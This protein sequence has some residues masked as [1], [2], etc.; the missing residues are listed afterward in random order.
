MLCPSIS[1]WNTQRS[2]IGKLMASTWCITVVCS[3]S[4]PTLDSSTAAMPSAVARCSCQNC[5]GETVPSQSTTWPMRANSSA[6]Y[7]A[8]S[9]DVP[10]SSAIQPRMPRVQSH[11]KAMKALGG[12]WGSAGG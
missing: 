12:R 3:A 8:S 9:A 2:R 10:V 6:S 11:T 5:A 7:S 4:R 1:R